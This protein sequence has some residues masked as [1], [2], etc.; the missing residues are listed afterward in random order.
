MF[1]IL[2]FMGV[3]TILDVPPNVSS[4]E[5]WLS[6]WMVSNLKLNAKLKTWSMMGSSLKSQQLFFL[7]NFQESS[8]DL[9]LDLTWKEFEN[10]VV[11]LPADL[12]NEVYLKEGGM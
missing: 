5:T 6:C 11:T 12:M 10:L 3:L 1:S 7:Y 4:G 8:L 9:V 2:F